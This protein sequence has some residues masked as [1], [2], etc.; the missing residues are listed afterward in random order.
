MSQQIDLGG[1]EANAISADSFFDD[2]DIQVPNIEIED[3]PQVPV[4]DIGGNNDNSGPV[5]DIGSPSDIK[6]SGTQ[7]SPVDTGFNPVE[8]VVFDKVQEPE[9]KGLFDQ[10]NM[11]TLSWDQAISNPGPGPSS[12]VSGS[13]KPEP[14]I[15]NDFSS[16]PDPEFN[17][18]SNPFLDEPEK[19]KVEVVGDYNFDF[20]HNKEKKK[21]EPKKEEPN[22]EE[23]IDYLSV[24]SK[25]SVIR[26]SKIKKRDPYIEEKKEPEL[27]FRGRNTLQ[28]TISE[29]SFGNDSR[30]LPNKYPGRSTFDENSNIGGISSGDMFSSNAQGSS[31]ENER[32][33]Y[34]RSNTLAPEPDDYY[35]QLPTFKTEAEEKKYYMIKL[36]S[37]ER[38]GIELTQT[39][40]NKSSLDEIRAEYREQNRILEEAEA[41]SFYKK[42][43]IAGSAGV[44]LL[45]KKY[46]PIGAKLDKW[47]DH[48]SNSIHDYDGV[49]ERI[50]RKYGGP[51]GHMDPL[52]ELVLGIGYSA[53][54]YH[55][56]NA[57]TD[58]LA[59]GA[60]NRFVNRPQEGIA[61]AFSQE[62]GN[63]YGKDT[64][65]PYQGR[66]PMQ[67]QPPMQQRVQRQP[68][69]PQ[70]QMSGPSL[71][72]GSLLQSVGLQVP[73]QQQ[74]N[75]GPSGTPLPRTAPGPSGV[76]INSGF[77]SFVD[78]IGT[79]GPPNPVATRDSGEPELSD[80]YRK[81]VGQGNTAENAMSKSQ[82]RRK[83]IQEDQRKNIKRAVSRVE[84]D[85]LSDI[86]IDSDGSEI[87]KVSIGRKKKGRGKK[88][89][90]MVL[91]F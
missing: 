70:Q 5:I 82:R 11:D 48:V 89:G 20:L 85:A 75:P 52:L 67:Q 68:Q 49:F 25:D 43:L 86:S 2:S 78:A 13:N 42:M 79:S 12:S 21:P 64:P 90:G 65:N 59:S 58:Q 72:I 73:Q 24:G 46:D 44:E 83:Q 74:Q 38:K 87:R 7:F 80:R 66:P 19:N 30:R 37:L 36:Q 35:D 27:R 15:K 41:V 51:G 40:T 28:R 81:M 3:S 50:H 17:D 18:T 1:I 39:L 22:Y 16:F 76:D 54:Q 84:N 6:T 31:Y 60:A 61:Q 33:S 29:S 45:N 26:Q 4:I 57:I 14:E 10:S 23:D 34:D 91:S 8:P 71:D 69:Q 77:G 56:V 53:F 63:V 62:F 32:S 55:M 47:S 9:N 88:K